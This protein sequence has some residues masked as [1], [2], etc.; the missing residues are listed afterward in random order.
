M[1]DHVN[2]PIYNAAAWLTAIVVTLLSVL[3][4]LLTIFP[5]LAGL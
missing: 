3:Y 2:G 1:G 4:I 5:G